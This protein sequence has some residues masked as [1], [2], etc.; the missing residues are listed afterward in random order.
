MI[1]YPTLCIHHRVDTTGALTQ[2]QLL[3]LA[4]EVLK[5]ERRDGGDI[6]TCH[7]LCNALWLASR[8]V[9]LAVR[10][11]AEKLRK[12]L[13]RRIEKDLGKHAYIH[14]WLIAKGYADAYAFD[15]KAGRRK[16]NKFRIQWAKSLAEEYR[17]K[18]K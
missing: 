16:L 17:Q 8:D 7:G 13:I 14:S 5:E 1:T 3:D 15:T 18:G 6:P 9:P 10:E 2:S 4:V 11:E 12:K